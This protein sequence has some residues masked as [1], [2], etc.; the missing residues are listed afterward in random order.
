MHYIPAKEQEQAQGR[1]RAGAVIG[2]G[3]V[4]GHEER[5]DLMC[6]NENWSRSGWASSTGEKGERWCRGVTVGKVKYTVR[7]WTG[8]QAG[9]E[10]TASVFIQLHGTKA[11]G[12][13]TQLRNDGEVNFKRGQIDTFTVTEF[14]LGEIESLTISHDNRSNFS[15]GFEAGWYLERVVVAAGNVEWVFP[16]RRWLSKDKEDG[17]LKRTLYASFADAQIKY[18]VIT[19]TGNSPDAGSRGRV[20]IQLHG[21]R[22]SAGPMVELRNPSLHDVFERGQKDLFI[23]KGK[24]IGAL[25]HVSVKFSADGGRG[26]WHL[27]GII[28]R[29]L[30]SNQD[31][32]FPFGRK[33]ANEEV[34][35][36]NHRAGA[37]IQSGE[38]SA[39]RQLEERA[40]QQALRPANRPLLLEDHDPYKGMIQHREPPCRYDITVV[41]SDVKGAGTDSNVFL[42]M[43]GSKKN[44]ISIRLSSHAVHTTRLFLRG[45]SDL[46]TLFLPDIGLLN[47]VCV[48]TDGQNLSDQGS[49]WHLAQL[50][51]SK[52]SPASSTPQSW[53]FPCNKC[54]DP[55]KGTLKM[56]LIPEGQKLRPSSAM[57]VVHVQESLHEDDETVRYEEE[58][59]NLRVMRRPLSAPRTTVLYNHS[60]RGGEERG[61]QLVARTSYKVKVKTGNK[62]YAGTDC[63][64]MIRI[65]GSARASATHRLSSCVVSHGSLFRRGA[66]DEFLIPEWHL[67]DPLLLSIWHD[68]RGSDPNWFLEKVTIIDSAGR[69]FL[70]PYNDWLSATE[71]SRKTRAEIPVKR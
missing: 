13:R 2:A 57:R 59:L 27:D 4:L 58:N 51:V 39:A 45:Q 22:G 6:L 25:S 10:T 64:V 29:N 5:S 70:F 16:C 14:D 11:D 18:K 52:T 54:F 30:R 37:Q 35:T 46:F 53:T 49:T 63:E 42:R 61:M 12:R 15:A 1:R 50:K 20:F 21:Q 68:A 66:T 44:T 19:F 28:V 56:D 32:P 65:K 41:T 62:P 9:A 7:T 43:F 48:W 69:E 60:S 23:I 67:G 8:N 31:F 55:D 40:V 17:Q 38:S 24:E 47:K 71:G 36:V 34:T 3:N 26:S 33:V